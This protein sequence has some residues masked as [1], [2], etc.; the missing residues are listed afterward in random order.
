MNKLISKLYI[1]WLIITAGL[2]AACS[3]DSF[4]LEGKDVTQHSFDMYQNGFFKGETGKEGY[5]L[6]D[7]VCLNLVDDKYE[8]KNI[9]MRGRLIGGCLDVLLNLCGTRFDK[10]K[11]YVLKY[12]DDGIIWFIESFSLGSEDI[13]RG[14]WQLYEAG[15]FENVK[16]FV[17]G[18]EAFFSTTTETDYRQ[19]LEHA[20]SKF[21]VPFVL[22]L[23]PTSLPDEAL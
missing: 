10:V 20:L 16:G 6:T 4:E 5:N 21:N 3:P 11:D 7:K 19:A 9:H 13:E 14:L 22:N 12:K 18:R 8:G 23:N 17:F 2:F 1:A 15:W